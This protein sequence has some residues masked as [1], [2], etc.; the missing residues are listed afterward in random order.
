MQCIKPSSWVSLPG[1]S[2]KKS[3]SSHRHLKSVRPNLQA[4]SLSLPSLNMTQAQQNIAES[5]GNKLLAAQQCMEPI[6]DSPWLTDSWLVAVAVFCSWQFWA[7][8]C[9][10]FSL[11]SEIDLSHSLCPLVR[12]FPHWPPL[13]HWEDQCSSCPHLFTQVCGSP[14]LVLAWSTCCGAQFPPP[15]WSSWSEGDGFGSDCKVC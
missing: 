13:G 1:Q 6:I 7:D 4:D 2:A 9:F 8:F 15:D 5:N 14:S 11:H 10:C 3:K 12:W